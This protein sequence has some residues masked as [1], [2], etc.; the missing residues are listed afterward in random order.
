MN[1]ERVV[2]FDGSGIGSGATA[3]QPGGVRQQWG[4]ELACR[5]ARESYEFYRGLGRTLEPTVDPKFSP[6]GYLF[7]A[8]TG[9]QLERLRGLAEMQRSCNVPVEI[10]Q[11]EDVAGLVTG[12]DS[13]GIEGASYCA[14][15]GYFDRP[16]S[17]V[18]GFAESAKRHGVEFAFTNVREIVEA[19][20]GWTLRLADGS[21]VTADHVVVAAATDTRHLLEPLGVD[22][23]IERESR[24]LFYSDPIAEVLLEPLVV[25]Q[26]RG[27]AAKH[28]ADGCVL[29]SDL[30]A[31]GEPALGRDTW[32][33]NIRESISALV[34]IL[35]YVS[36]P[37]LVEGWY[38]VT[39]D[40]QPIIGEIP[41]REGLW[42]AAGLNGRGLMMAP[43]IGRAVANAISGGVE[44]DDVLVSLSAKRFEGD[45]LVP[46]SQVV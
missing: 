7:L 40:R 9:A 3:V 22:L 36:F 27:F 17:L 11:P 33:R 42:V 39:P 10:L 43:S 34:P 29:A 5:M 31:T 26:E 46:E 24:Y 6:C 15:D 30:R 37:V 28:L 19:V 41:G 18:A 35:E 44:S 38:D 20:E 23:P 16:Q 25:A 45:T 13:S 21:S 8:E 4:T 12:I 2:V 32:L 14:E 1:H